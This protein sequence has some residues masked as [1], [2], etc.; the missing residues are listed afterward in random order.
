[1]Y[2]LC[3]SWN[4]QQLFTDLEAPM[5]IK[6]SVDKLVREI[7][8]FGNPLVFPC[9][10]TRRKCCGQALRLLSTMIPTQ[11]IRLMQNQVGRLISERC[12]R[13]VGIS[14]DEIS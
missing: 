12:L 11:T 4:S 3:P 5:S 6:A 9:L 13:G 1:M 10:R 2:L 14:S 8:Q 7:Q